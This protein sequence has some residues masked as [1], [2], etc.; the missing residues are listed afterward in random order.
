MATNNGTPFSNKTLLGMWYEDQLSSED[1]LPGVV[2]KG[3]RAVLDTRR[4]VLPEGVGKRGV[5]E[6]LSGGDY[7]RIPDSVYR[8]SRERLRRTRQGGSAAQRQ[9]GPSRLGPDEAGADHF[10]T[11]AH[12]SFGGKHSDSAS[13]R[14]Y[15]A[16]GVRG[17]PEG[18]AAG[19]VV[20]HDGEGGEVERVTKRLEPV[21][22]IQK[23]WLPNPSLAFVQRPARVAVP[24]GERPALICGSASLNRTLAAHRGK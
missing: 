5:F 24:A 13:A 10:R 8:E 23:M 4:R 16:E 7:A 2:G 15:A 17:A 9:S 14:E 18:V 22:P 3:G 1:A 12:S 6:S 11:T 20:A 19:R 21:D